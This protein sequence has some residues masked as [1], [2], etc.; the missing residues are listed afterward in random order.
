MSYIKDEDDDAPGEE[1]GVVDTSSSSSSPTSHSPGGEEVGERHGYSLKGVRRD[2]S[3]EEEDGEEEEGKGRHVPKKHSYSYIRRAAGSFRRGD[4]GDG[5]GL[6]SGSVGVGS[7]SASRPHD[8]NGGDGLGRNVKPYPIRRYPS[9][10]S[11]S[12]QS[13]LVA[14]QL[15]GDNDASSIAD[16]LRS[17]APGHGLTQSNIQDHIRKENSRHYRKYQQ[18]HHRS[19]GDEDEEEDE[20]DEYGGRIGM[21]SS[22]R[23][24]GHEG[25]RRGDR[26][27]GSRRAKADIKEASEGQ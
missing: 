3:D 19:R 12:S 20:D 22:S 5:E 4:A 24:T 14:K 10:E 25:G 1:M 26:R 8:R 21:G 16:I 27:S 9:N 17:T 23:R 2:G 7:M 18:H 6:V 13:T 15:G 11:M